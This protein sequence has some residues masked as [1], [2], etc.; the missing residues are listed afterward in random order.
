M[1]RVAPT[2]MIPESSGEMENIHGRENEGEHG[3]HSNRVQWEIEI[4][5]HLPGRFLVSSL[6]VQTTFENV[7]RNCQKR[8]IGPRVGR[9][10]NKVVRTILFTPRAW[11]LLPTVGCCPKRFVLLQ[12][13][14]EHE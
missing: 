5:F 14:K 10:T 9:F 3:E 1:S 2:R 11:I 7:K 4:G 12:P 13:C 8:K 6:V